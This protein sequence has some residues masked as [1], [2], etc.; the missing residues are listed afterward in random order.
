MSFT[1]QVKEALHIGRCR[2]K[3]RVVIASC[4]FKKHVYNKTERCTSC[5]FHA[6]TVISFLKNVLLDVF[7][8]FSK[9][10]H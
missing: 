1:M 3:L 7:S 8:S 9:G 10:P 6:P 4:Y 5:K 2:L